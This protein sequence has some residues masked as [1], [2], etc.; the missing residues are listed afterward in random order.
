ME[1]FLTDK[2][3][4]E[5]VICTTRFRNGKKRGADLCRGG[6][7]TVEEIAARTP[8]SSLGCNFRARPSTPMRG[9]E[10]WRRAMK[11]T[12]RARRA[13]PS[14]TPPRDHRG[15][16]YIYPSVSDQAVSYHLPEYWAYYDHGSGPGRIGPGQT[17]VP[18]SAPT[19]SSEFSASSAQQGDD[20]IR[21]LNSSNSLLPA[22]QPA[23]SSAIS[24]NDEPLTPTIGADFTKVKR[25]AW[26][27]DMPK[28]ANT[29]YTPD[30][31]DLDSLKDSLEQQLSPKVQIEMSG[32]AV[33]TDDT[34]YRGILDPEILLPGSEDAGP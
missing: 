18:G 25:W 15:H 1:W 10:S 28:Y 3:L 20:G 30:E 23:N 8:H 31:N 13:L 21:A 11:R 22:D 4:R 12:S 7:P 5:G 14:L 29:S 32:T 33:L 24:D 2:A 19:N 9:A 17:T 34:D 26:N 27:I 16:D 6:T